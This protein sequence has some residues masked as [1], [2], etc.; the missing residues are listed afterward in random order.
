MLPWKSASVCYRVFLLSMGFVFIA[1][2]QEVG[3]YSEQ[4]KERKNATTILG[5][6]Y[7]IIIYYYCSNNAE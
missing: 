4:K 3:E 7:F 2:S 1:C 6:F 5:S